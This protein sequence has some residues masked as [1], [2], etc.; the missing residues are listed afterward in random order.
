LLPADE[1]L[2]MLHSLAGGRLLGQRFGSGTPNVL[3]LH[4]W[5]RTHRDF[6]A[7]LAPFALDPLDAIALDLAG[8]GSAPAPPD[9]W[10]TADYADLVSLVLDEM[11]PQVVVLGHSF[12]GRVAVQL[13]AARPQEVQTLVLSG[14]PDLV[15]RTRRPQAALRF[16]AARRL[17]R[18]G[19]LSDERIESARQ[20]H[21]SADYRAAVGVMRQ[22]LVKTLAEDY[23]DQLASIGCPISLVWGDNDTEAPIAG[24]EELVRTHPGTSLTV[25]PG[26]GHLTPLTAPVVLREAVVDALA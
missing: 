6:D 22:V 1:R 10:G 8:F 12:G 21:G 5:G 11:T 16:R 9:A 19:V 26:A 4:G 25:C 24:A 15:R 13:A 17:H 7:V 2:R 20:R 3:A 23:Q 18:W 14:V